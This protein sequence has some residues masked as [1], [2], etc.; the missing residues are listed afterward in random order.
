MDSNTRYLAINTKISTM[1][2]KLLKEEDYKK[3][4]SFKNPTE[5]AVYLKNS[6]AYGEFFKDMDPTQMHRTE[7]EQILKQGL[8]NYMDKVIHY[9][10]G[11][12]RNFIKSFY[13][14]YEI[15]DIKRVA[16]LIYIDKDFGD[17][18]GNL[19]FAGKYKYIDMDR[20]IMS[21]SISE[22]VSA[23]KNTIY[24]PFLKNLIDGNSE[25]SLYRFEMSIDKAY[26]YILEDSVKHLLKEDRTVFYSLVGSSIDMLNLRWIY[27]GKKYY[28][29]T[30]EELFNYT[31]N[32]GCRY[33]Y[34]KIKEFCYCKS[35]SEFLNMVKDTPYAFMFK[36]C[37]EDDTFVERRMNRYLYF[38][39]K[40]A[41]RRSNLDL[42]ML[43]AYLDLIEFEIRDIISMIENVR[44]GM[45]YEETRKYLIKAI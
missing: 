24:Y 12:Y 40:S 30:P 43:L 32:K 11:E 41:K 1:Y 17:L 15:T 2:G 36:G 33:N 21:K 27:R 10:S 44:Y 45:D 29:V 14:K 5:I 6:T 7:I 26:F 37:P 8:I 31:V 38:K 28:K 22:I 19:I 23:L 39:M 13:T 42:S 34:R 35:I 16:R 18:K 20:V 25:E 9:F 3:I 4:I